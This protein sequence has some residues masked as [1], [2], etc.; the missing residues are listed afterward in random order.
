MNDN[1]HVVCPHCGAVNRIP[2]GRLGEGGRCGRCHKPLFTGHP[3]E[4]TSA[5]F[6][7]FVSRNDL[8]V[9]VDFWAPW[10]GPCRMMAPVLDEAAR[11]LE[12]HLRIAKVNTEDDPMLAQQFGIRGIPTLALF[13][14]GREI[15]RQSGAMPLPQLV[16]WLRQHI[17]L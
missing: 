2:V 12:P 4:L 15:A 6:G 1:L 17:P 10:C 16:Q 3:V 5:T 8:P 7:R 9:L 11:T 14:S 13:R